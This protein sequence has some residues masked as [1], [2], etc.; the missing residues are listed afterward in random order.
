MT[1]PPKP[2]RKKITDYVVKVLNG[3]AQGLFASLL[4]GLIIKQVGVLTGW[5]LLVHFGTTAQS[6]MGPAIG[7]AVA[8]SV[9]A[10]PL[11]IFASLATGALG[12]GTFSVVDGVVRAGIGEPVGAL[13]AGLIGAEAGKLVHGRTSVGIIVVPITVILL[14]GLSGHYIAPFIAAFMALLG[15]FINTA[16]ELH[17]IP[18]G[19]IVATA[20]GM[21]LTLPIS[22]AALAVSLGLSGIA[23]GASAVGCAS[24]MVGFAVSSY[25]ENGIGGLLSQ[26]LGTSML[27]IP[28]I[29]K[30]PRIWIPPTLTAAILGPLASFVFR[31][32]G[33]RVG[34]GM[35]TSGLVG[36]FDAISVMGAVPRTY[37]LLFLLHFLLPALLT[38]LFSEILRRK[39]WIKPGD[40]KL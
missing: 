32:E 38:L 31:M 13:V 15:G 25:R 11:V 19:I 16:T 36:Q 26:G 1:K 33:T 27:Q 5:T 23:A 22:S 17:P 24:Q 39:G 4:I 10:P 34:A 18:M 21:I 37:F 3:M 9:G 40:M 29:V 28:N 14:G 35:G 7:A 2:T 6:L 20:M 12:A 30:N 8:Y